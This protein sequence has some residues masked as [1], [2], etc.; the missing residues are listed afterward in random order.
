MHSGSDE[1]AALERRYLREVTGRMSHREALRVFAALWDQA[2]RMNPN[3][4]GPWEDDIEADLELARVLN[5]LPD[6]L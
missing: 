4:P 2:I 3:F 5:G 6:P 1:V